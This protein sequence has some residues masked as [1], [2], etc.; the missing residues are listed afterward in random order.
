MIL[1]GEKFEQTAKNDFL[2]VQLN[3]KDV[4]NKN[5][6]VYAKQNY[7]TLKCYR[8]SHVRPV[9]LLYYFKV[10]L[11][12]YA[13][14]KISSYSLSRSIINELYENH[15]FWLVFDIS[16]WKILDLKSVYVMFLLLLIYGVFRNLTTIVF[17]NM[18]SQ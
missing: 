4:K 1:R 9:V 8:I 11:S 2:L 12:N 18:I 10:S 16:Y 7:N 6:T 13:F 5:D 14:R 15:K 3:C 17:H